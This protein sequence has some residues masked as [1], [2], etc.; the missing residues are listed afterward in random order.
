MAKPPKKTGKKVVSI[1]PKI[2]EK[3]HA[4]QTSKLLS[5]LGTKLTKLS[6]Q[7]YDV[8]N[9]AETLKLIYRM[10]LRGK[11][12]LKELIKLKEELES[13]KLKKK[14]SPKTKPS[15]TLVPEDKE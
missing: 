7:G 3:Q 14:P 13:A 15:L 10:K 2:K 6:K 4:D 1:T 5:T 11:A 8:K 12:P 9:Q